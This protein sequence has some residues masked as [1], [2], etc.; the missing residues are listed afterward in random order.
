MPAGEFPN[1]IV[2]QGDHPLNPLFVA[3]DLG[4]YRLDDSSPDWEP[5]FTN[6][7]N[8]DIRDLSINLEDHSITA[9]TYGRGLWRSSNSC[10]ITR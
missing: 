3:T 4:V 2:H 8:V 10:T 7:P 1:A 6:L 5:F 9:A